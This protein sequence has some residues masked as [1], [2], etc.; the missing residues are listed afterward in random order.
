MDLK[1]IKK[2]AIDNELSINYILKDLEISKIFK[3]LENT[4][5]NT[6][7]KGRTVI[8]RVYFKKENRRF[9]EHIEFDF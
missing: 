8:N 4:L 5:E 9:S 7:L 6:I 3:L 1:D 2:L